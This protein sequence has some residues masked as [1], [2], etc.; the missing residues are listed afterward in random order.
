MLLFWLAWSQRCFAAT[1]HINQTKANQIRPSPEFKPP[2]SIVSAMTSPAVV[3]S[4]MKQIMVKEKGSNYR[5]AT[6]IV[7]VPVPEPQAKQV[8]V[9]ISYAAINA[10]DVLLCDGF[11]TPGLQP[12]YPAGLEAMGEIVATGEGSKLAV[13]QNVN[14]FKIGSFSEYVVLDDELV[15]VIPSADPANLLIAISGLTASIALERKGNIKS[16]DTL[17]VTAAAG[18]T[19]QFAVQ[20]GKLAGCH[21][22]GTCSTDEKAEFLKSIGCDRPVVYTR[23][24]LDEVLKQEYPNGVD[25]VY[26]SIGNEIFDTCFKNLSRYGRIIVIGVISGYEK[27]G[28]YTIPATKLP[29]PF[30]TVD[31]SC[32]ILGFFLGHYGADMS[33]HAE[34]LAKLMSSGQLKAEV[35]NGEKS[36]KGPFRGIDMVYDAI[37]HMYAKKNTGKVVVAIGAGSTKATVPV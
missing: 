1:C 35:D 28:S 7:T 11:Y 22:I 20:L 6:E 4:Q 14:F 33:V 18:A 16:G 2:S 12:P 31:K 32:D 5:K 27:D 30:A 19:G 25:V 17:L 37:D 36:E 13:G 21:V 10:S 29:F 24:S 3:P 26:E 8:L 15:T 9:R 34:R 23:E